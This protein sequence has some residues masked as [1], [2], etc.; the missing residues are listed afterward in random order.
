MVCK[1]SSVS[2]MHVYD[3]SNEKIHCTKEV[4]CSQLKTKT[5]YSCTIT[6]EN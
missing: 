2:K 3:V 1:Q 4:W 6:Y 5:L